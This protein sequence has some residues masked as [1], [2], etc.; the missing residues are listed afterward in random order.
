QKLLVF[1]IM[2]IQQSFSVSFQY[3]VHFTDHLFDPSN[4]IFNDVLE[5]AHQPNSC[6][7]L[8]FIIDQNI[9]IHFPQLFDQIDLYFKDNEFVHLIPEKIVVGG[10]E[11]V[12]N[13]TQYFDQIVD[14]INRHG[15]D[16]HSYVAA[17]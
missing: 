13:D 8:L 2:F 4:H 17:I 3:K 5:E 11:I 10:G 6:R 16:R 12:K 14:A 15:I 7:K 9:E 1:I